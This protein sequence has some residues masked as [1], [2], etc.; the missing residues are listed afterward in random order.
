MSRAGTTRSRRVHAAHSEE[1]GDERWL[2]SYSDMITVLMALFIVMFAISSVDQGKYDELR[3]AL[4]TG[5][6]QTDL[7]RVDITEGVVV[8]PEEMPGPAAT[9]QP[10]TDA[11]RAAVEL[12]SLEQLRDHVAAALAAD[13]LA[14]AARLTLDER[15]LTI[16]LVTSEMF[17]EPNRAELTSRAV[18]V[19]D[20]VTPVV[21]AS[22]YAVSVEG[23]AD[24]RTG[25]YPFPTNWELSSGRATQVVR[26]MIATGGIGP[27]RIAAVGFGDSRPLA[28]GSAPDALAMNRRVDIVVLSDAPES[29]RALLPQL[30]SE[31]T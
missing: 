29:V 22:R 1:G 30:L 2:V 11:D 17:F 26:H 16:G 28:D 21:V 18:Q 25:T 4:S 5:F 31:G 19:L 7:G 13:G 20:A 10:E 24:H 23:H 27:E 8:P 14:G 12:A 3:N 15:G 6:G 9:P